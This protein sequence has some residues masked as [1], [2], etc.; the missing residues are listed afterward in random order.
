MAAALVHARQVACILGR[1]KQDIGT[2]GVRRLAQAPKCNW[3]S[4]VPCPAALGMS[5]KP[6]RCL[7]MRLTRTWQCAVDG[8]LVNDYDGRIDCAS[9]ITRKESNIC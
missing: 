5:N 9:V 1:M 6:L 2:L 4:Y 3:G 7:C 8:M